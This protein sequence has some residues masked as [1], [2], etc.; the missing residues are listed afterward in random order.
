MALF[1]YDA[2]RK[3]PRYTHTHTQSTHPKSIRADF[4]CKS[5][6]GEAKGAC[7]PDGSERKQLIDRLPAGL[8]RNTPKQRTGYTRQT[9]EQVH[10]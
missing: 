4:K 2:D 3:E 6:N 7:V 10:I 9:Y 5:I 8:G 1:I